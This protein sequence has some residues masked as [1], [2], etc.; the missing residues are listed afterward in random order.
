[1]SEPSTKLSVRVL[2]V[3]PSPPFYAGIRDCLML[4]RHVPLGQVRNLEEALRQADSLHPDLILVG[5]HIVE[6]ESLAVCREVS[7]RWPSI[8]TI[9]FTMHADDPLFQSDAVYA[10]AAACLW[11]GVTDEECLK[12]VD[13]VMAGHQLFSREILAPDRQP[14][15]LTARERE[16]L[17]LIA[18]GKTDR[19]IANTLVLSHRTVRNYSQRI[20][21]KLGIHSRQE[22]VRRARRRGLI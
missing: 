21:Q 17:K 16:V 4:G 22:A 13:A 15:A 18:E 10:G 5:P 9:I 3:D 12:A 8:K 2:L 19:E 20:L 14:I 11:Q 6:D 1:M 7:S